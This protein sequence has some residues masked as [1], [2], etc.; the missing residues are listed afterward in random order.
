MEK[1]VNY[2]L[3]HRNYSALCFECASFIVLMVISYTAMQSNRQ[4][5]SLNDDLLTI[6]FIIIQLLY[7]LNGIRD[8]FIAKITNRSPFF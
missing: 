8:I 7:V 2:L 4:S 1:Q 5:N 6:Y 3:L